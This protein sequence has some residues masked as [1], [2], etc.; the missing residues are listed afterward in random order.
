MPRAVRA[1][2]ALWLVLMVVLAVLMW[3]NLIGGLGTAIYGLVVLAVMAAE[4][5]L[6][7][8]QPASR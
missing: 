2:R 1:L 6:R 4:M 7:R 8:R 3:F 5:V